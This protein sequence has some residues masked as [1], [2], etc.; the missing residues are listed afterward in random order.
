MSR[1]PF[2]AAA[3]NG[4]VIAVTGAD[5]GYGRL[6]S[7][8]L[9]RAGASVVMIGGN[10]ETLAATA[11]VLEQYGAEI[12][13]LKADV[14]VPLDF[15]SAQERILQI[16]GALH[17]VVHLADRRASTT[18]AMLTENEWMDLFNC[19]VKSTVG[20]AQILAR[21]LPGTWL[22]V[23]GPH[24]DEPGLQ[25]YPQR[26]ALQGLVEHAHREEL[27]VNLLLPGRASS[28]E[29]MLDA[30]VA[31]AVLALATTC[32]QSLRGNVMQ[33]PLA[34]APKV[35]LPDLQYL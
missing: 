24:L 2:S 7:Q 13:P 8:A 14:S 22:T 6:V 15:I 18:F 10:T 20:I 5:Q 11:S 29:E 4:Q 1:P 19:N 12:I 33:I 21:R 28:G 34:P 23:I 31:D 27:R 17:G 9:A 30:P 3:L 26:G 16:F 35:R 25:A 32:L